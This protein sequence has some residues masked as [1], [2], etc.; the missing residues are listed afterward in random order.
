MV[1]LEVVKYVLLGLHVIGVA[2]ILGGVIYQMP[3]MRRGEA[4]LVSGILH[5]AW[6]ML[7][8]GVALVGLNYPLDVP[9]NNIKISVKLAVLIAIIVI[10]LIHRKRQPLKTWVLPTIGALTVLNVFLATV[11][12]SYS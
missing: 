6:L 2:G 3:A 10:A 5:G 1:A 8:T 4:K 12:R 9:V 7:I 11:W